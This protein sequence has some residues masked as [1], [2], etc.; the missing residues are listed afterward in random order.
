MSLARDERLALC[1]SLE[2]IGPDAPTLCPPWRTRDLA[3]HLV[4]RERRPDAA[5]G[6][7][8]KALAGRLKRVQDGYAAKPWPALVELVRTGPPVWSPTRLHAVDER[9]N[10]AEFFVHHEDVLRAQPGWTPRPR[11]PQLERALWHS[12]KRTAPLMF[13]RCPVG[14]VL[15]TPEHGRAEVRAATDAGTVVVRGTPGEL[16]LLAFNRRDVARVEVDGPPAALKTFETA[17]IGLT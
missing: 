15:E 16:T 12:L 6:I 2:R 7:V 3:A 4:V 17:P 11:R 1:D 10:L 13:R 5:G 9:A 8:L 14:V